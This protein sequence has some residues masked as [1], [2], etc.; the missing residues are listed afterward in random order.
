M[1]TIRYRLNCQTLGIDDGNHNPRVVMIP[2][3]SRVT[4][5][6]AKLG[7]RLITVLWEGKPVM[8]FA[9]DLDER[10]IREESQAT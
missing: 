4:V 9:Q 1:Q 8:I 7:S 5:A 2:K 3:G 6:E 10:G